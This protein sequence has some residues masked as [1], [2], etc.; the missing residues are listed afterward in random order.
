MKKILLLIVVI[1][2][3]TDVF[4]QC[5]SLDKLFVLCQVGLEQKD[6]ILNKLNFQLSDA[7]ET[8]IDMFGPE[9]YNKITDNYITIKSTNDKFKL[10]YRLKGNIECYNK[11]KTEVI[12]NNFTKDFERYDQY[13]TL[14]FYYSNDKYGIIF[15][16][17][18]AP[19]GYSGNFFSVEI[20]DK[21]QYQIE[22]N[23]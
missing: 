1:L 19:E 6:E 11:L 5:I 10:N 8:R 20:L 13:N 7:N 18:K 4:S 17:W 15:S 2:L 9:W 22:M 14:I 23:N 21:K 3:S 16:K 12:E